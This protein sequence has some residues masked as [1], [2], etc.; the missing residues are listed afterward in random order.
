MLRLPDGRVAF[1]DFGLFKHL[2][3]SAVE[4]ELACQR[5]VVEGDAPELHRLLTES[6]FV[7][8]PEKLDPDK[9]MT[10]VVDGIG[11]YTTADEPVQLAPELAARVALETADPRSSH[12]ETMRH[13]DID[14][15]HLIGRRMEM[16][17]L[18]VLAQLRARNNWHRIAR[19]WIYGDR[20][21]TE[22]GEL[23]AGFFGSVAR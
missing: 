20:P 21:V 19:E 9:L 18:A 11:W 6:G 16:L 13:Q 12:F 23:E 1:L 10:Y 14:P 5:A 3:D 7:P 22:L 4:L 8:E 15:E 17:T 2:H